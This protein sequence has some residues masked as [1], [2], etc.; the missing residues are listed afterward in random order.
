MPR[1][2]F[3]QPLS[4][5]TQPTKELNLGSGFHLESGKRLVSTLAIQFVLLLLTTLGSAQA[6]QPRVPETTR[7]PHGK[8]DIPCQN[9][10]TF[11][12]WKP[13]RS[14]PE[15]DHNKTRYP[16]R[17]LHK[18]VACVQCHTNAVFNNVGN[19]CAD[20]H[21]DIHRR[22]MGSQCEQCHSVNGWTISLK[23]IREH[24]NRFPLIG[25][26]AVVDCESCHKGAAVGQYKG[27]STDCVGCHMSSYLTT[28]SPSHTAL[29]FPTQCQQCH[30][31]MDSWAGAR[32]DHAALTGFALVGAHAQLDCV[33][34]HVGGHYQGTP[35]NCIGCHAK[36]YNGAKDPNHVSLG[37]TQACSQCH[38]T[39]TWLGAKFDHAST[40]FVLTGAHTTLSC[41]SCHT[42]AT[43]TAANTTC[44]SCHL[45]DFN[46]TQSPNHV[47]IGFSQQCT[48][49]HNTTTWMGA[50]FDHASTG[51]ALTGAHAT[52]NC[53]SCHTGGTL[54]TANATCVACHLNDFNKTTNPNHVT[55]WFSQQCNVCH[56]TTAWQPASFDHSKT[57]FPLTGAHTTVPCLT[58]HVGGKY[59]G[60]PTDCSACHMTEYQKTTNPSHTVVAFPTTCQTCHSTSDWLSATFNHATTGFA[61][62]GAHT[63]QPCSS[64]HAGTPLTAANTA[65]SSC[66]LTEY[67]KTTN[68]SHTMVA[69]PTTCQ[70]CHSTTDWLSAKF[71]HATTGFPL[72]GTHATQACSACHAG[73]P[74]TAANTACSSCHISTYQKTTNP[75][76]IAVG[77]PTDCSLCHGTTNWLSATFDH[78]TT[79]WGLTGAHT[80]LGCSSCHGAVMLTSANTACASCHLKNYNSTTNPNHVTAAFPQQCEICHSTTVWQPATF[81]HSK[82]VFPLTGAHTTVACASCHI[83]GKYAGTPTDCYSCHK[84]EYTTVTNPNHV[85]AGF[86]TTCLT[87]H[88]TTT[89]AGATFNHTWFKIP[90]HS[91][92]LCSDC[93]TNPSNYTVFLCTNCHTQTQTTSQHSGVKGFVWNSTNC[94]SCHK[95]GGGG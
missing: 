52:L 25:A 7:S 16:L 66:H 32:F 71:D 79:G 58:C 61:L 39:T 2:S 13:I 94:Y 38:S 49:C 82:T 59:A 35:T 3:S 37:F 70:T 83:G 4:W 43:L 81:D 44:V 76:H 19:K 84:T 87:C 22:Q 85:A 75:N 40:G 45:N 62:T 6:Q 91:A 63:T 8:L 46:G 23:S 60:T 89:W 74:L 55:G 36:D 68:P 51:F 56:T 10:H 34:C 48:L 53:S 65:C 57:V 17:G 86:P 77:F 50:T 93:H 21:A 31:T 54:T 26:H 88:T 47:T 69:I 72:T 41:S 11:S 29:G 90:H 92:Q 12:G 80:T 5:G 95:N 73:T 64:C 15:F 9:C 14:V 42:G 28:K 27:L 24:Q 67:Q 33:A 20:C 1:R 78:S 30:T 18:N